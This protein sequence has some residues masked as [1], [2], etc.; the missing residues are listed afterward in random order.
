MSG[1]TS[2]H[3]KNCRS[4]CNLE[5][6]CIHQETPSRFLGSEIKSGK[7][8]EIFNTDLIPEIYVGSKYKTFMARERSE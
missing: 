3:L 7:T 5:K 2:M 6:N 4:Y 8:P 1:Y